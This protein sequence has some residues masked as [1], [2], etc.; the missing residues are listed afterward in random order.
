M[1]DTG[2]HSAKIRVLV[3]DEHSL[4]RYGISTYLNSQPDMVVCGEADNIAGA[5]SKI[6]ECQPQLLVTDLRLAG[7]DS[8]KLVKQLKAEKPALRILVYS[9][10]EESIFAERAMRAGAHGY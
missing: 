2:K 8:L 7:G 1:N 4:L 5:G 9:A 10:F 6:D 3:L